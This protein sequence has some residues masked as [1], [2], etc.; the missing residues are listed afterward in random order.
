MPVDTTT[1][2]SRRALLGAAAGAAAAAA[3]AA[4]IPASVAG[5]DPNDVV[6][7]ADN[8]T[9][10]RTKVT[11][12]V[13]GGDGAALVGENSSPGGQGVLGIADL[14]GGIGVVGRAS[15]G[16]GVR[17]AGY[18]YGVDA[19]GYSSGVRAWTGD[20]AGAAVYGY[21]GNGSSPPAPSAGAAVLA[22]APD[23]ATTALEVLG[24]VKF[25]RSGK[26][27]MSAAQTSKA[28]T[29]AGVTTSS[30][31]LA[32]LQTR[33]SGLSILAV[34]PGAGKFTIYLNKAPGKTI[35]IGYLIIN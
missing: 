17:A 4:A 35:S 11:S 6:L 20:N 19:S 13:M 12:S 18:L 33:V 26:A 1:P 10:T 25:S 16:T 29:K 15:N 34:V 2:R 32:T 9:T 28:V 30:Y 14:Q 23:V 24:K 5:A 7:G 8:T 31:V 21:L 22:S 3:A 27:S